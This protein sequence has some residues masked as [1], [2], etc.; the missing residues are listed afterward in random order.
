M[1]LSGI[2]R[3]AEYLN[4]TC[5]NVTYHMYSGVIKYVYNFLD[6]AGVCIR[7]Y[8]SLGACLI[9]II[10]IVEYSGRLPSCG[11]GPSPSYGTAHNQKQKH[12]CFCAPPEEKKKG[13]MP[14]AAFLSA[15]YKDSLRPVQ[16]GQ[17]ML[18]AW[19]A[20]FSDTFTSDTFTHVP[21][22]TP[23]PIKLMPEKERI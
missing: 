19:G 6:R 21:H 20:V 13:H 12:A 4:R 2:K 3:R 5:Y 17:S 14:S 1:G 10:I 11:T 18:Y 8:G 23:S 16:S 9:G 15:W 7:H 22:K